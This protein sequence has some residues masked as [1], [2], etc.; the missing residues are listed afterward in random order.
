MKHCHFSILYNELPFLKQKLPFLYEHFDQ[1]IFYDLH[2]NRFTFS[3]DGSHEF[4]KAYPDPKRKIKLIEKK[5]LSDVHKFFGGS[6]VTK[7]KMFAVGSRHVRNNIDVF[8]CTDMD[9]FFTE[10][11]IGK[12]EDT[13]AGNK[14]NTV[15]VPHLIFFKSDKWVFAKKDGDDLIWLGWP[16]IAR[17]TKGNIYGH[18]SLNKQFPPVHRLKGEILYHFS[19]VGD[20]KMR[21]KAGL[22]VPKQYLTSVW[23][24]FNEKQAL[25]ATGV[26]KPGRMH[27]SCPWG[28]VQN[29]RPIPS[30]IDTKQLIKELNGSKD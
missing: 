16:R 5:D 8:W 14:Y 10:S 17:H 30:Y 26:Y 9:E 19:Y 11:L 24:K 13:I 1:I 7:R 23:N 3:N 22:Q 25:K 12:V 29:T 4:I 6:F 28:I 27:P 15:L 2:V 18:C 21:I 20:A